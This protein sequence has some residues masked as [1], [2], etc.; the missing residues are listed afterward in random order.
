MAPDFGLVPGKLD[1]TTL[2]TRIMFP[3]LLLVSL[4]ALAMGILNSQ[5][6]IFPP[7]PGL[8]F[9]QPGVHRGRA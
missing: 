1:L 4:A 3:F 5:G 2:M 8:Q 9:F 7:V 6:E